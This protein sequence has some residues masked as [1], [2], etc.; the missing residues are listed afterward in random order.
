MFGLFALS[1]AR[2]LALCNR[3]SRRVD[4]RRA[5]RTHS[6]YLVRRGR[7]VADSAPARER[8]I[9]GSSK[10]RQPPHVALASTTRPRHATRVY[11]RLG[12][13][14]TPHGRVSPS[15]R[16]TPLLDTKASATR[17][18]SARRID[19]RACPLCV[20]APHAIGGGNDTCNSTEHWGG[21]Y[22]CR[23]CSRSLADRPG[24]PYRK[25]SSSR[26]VP[27]MTRE[28]DRTDIAHRPS[29]ANSCRR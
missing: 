3:R 11:R 2:R 20:S 23:T 24:H 4:D 29:S 13:S 28:H 5:G 21:V 17:T 6:G 1:A 15:E 25:S 27:A 22:P 14:A 26:H 9:D 10:S 19:S 18:A 7:L 16:P 8:R 12:G